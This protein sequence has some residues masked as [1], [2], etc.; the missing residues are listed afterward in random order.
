M[1]PSVVA[2]K[3]IDFVKGE[4]QKELIIERPKK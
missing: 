2:Q 1:D 4:Y 3:I